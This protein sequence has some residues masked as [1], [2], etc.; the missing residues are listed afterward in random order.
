MKCNACHAK[1]SNEN[2]QQTHEEKQTTNSQRKNKQKQSRED[3][4]Q[5]EKSILPATHSQTFP[6]SYPASSARWTSAVAAA[7]APA[8]PSAPAA[9]A[10]EQPAPARGRAARE[11]LDFPAAV[12]HSPVAP[13]AAVAAPRFVVPVAAAVVA[14]AEAAAAVAARAAA[15]P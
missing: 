13:L 14:A 4:N 15:A 1:K 11:E 9:V 8:G 6:S 3:E 2:K 7:V 10:A 12:V 5:K